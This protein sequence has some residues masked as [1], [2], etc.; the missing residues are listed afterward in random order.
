MR[1]FTALTIALAVTT[2]GSAFA[3]PRSHAPAAHHEAR[4]EEGTAHAPAGQAVHG[5]EN[6]ASESKAATGEDKAKSAEVSHEVRPSLGGNVMAPTS[7]VEAQAV[8]VTS[9]LVKLSE[10]SRNYKASST[11]V[12]TVKDMMDNLLRID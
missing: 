10:K 9:D 1:P 12:G 2:T 3:G 5:I 11:A 4:S 6:K 7:A 8:D